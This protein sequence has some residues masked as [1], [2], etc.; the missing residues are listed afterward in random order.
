MVFVVCYVV[1]LHCPSASTTRHRP[2]S[3][4]M[5]KEAIQ[6]IPS[7]FS[8][9]VVNEA[10]LI[11][12]RLYALRLVM[13]LKELDPAEVT[14]ASELVTPRHVLGA[15]SGVTAAALGT[16][17][18][19]TEATEVVH[20]PTEEPADDV[21]KDDGQQTAEVDV[22]TK[23]SK[24]V[25]V[26]EAALSSVADFIRKENGN[27][28]KA[29]RRY[30]AGFQ[31]LEHMC[32][33]IHNG[34]R[35]S[36]R[37][38]VC[39]AMPFAGHGLQ[40]TSLGTLQLGW[41][42]GPEAVDDYVKHLFWQDSVPELGHAPPCRSYRFLVVFESFKQYELQIAKAVGREQITN[43]FVSMKTFKAAYADLVSMCKASGARLKSTLEFLAKKEEVD[44]A[45]G[46]AAKVGRGRPRKSLADTAATSPFVENPSAVH[47]WSCRKVCRTS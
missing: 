31:D 37:P 26:A 12:N 24:A 4:P 27:V 40:T 16:L 14:E 45:L 9:N 2:T 10:K 33:A 38:A 20:S 39:R 1:V 6:S 36:S 5:S 41:P 22:G 15:G 46:D 35:L 13:G 29:L 25:A 7:R 3:V 47:W 28:E 34:L 42:F 11:K 8:A 21:K 18:A 17:A 43:I 23:D 44:K 19:A 32:H 30:I